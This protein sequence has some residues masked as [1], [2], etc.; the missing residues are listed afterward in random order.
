MSRQSI[1][2]SGVL[3]SATSSA[4]AALLTT[5]LLLMSCETG[6]TVIGASKHLELAFNFST[7]DVDLSDAQ[8][9]A[10]GFILSQ[11]ESDLRPEWIDAQIGRITPFQ[12][13]D[14]VIMSYEVEILSSIGEPRGW[15]MVEAWHWLDPVSAY[16]TSGPPMSIALLNDC[17]STTGETLASIERSGYRFLW[18]GHGTQALEVLGVDGWERYAPTPEI[19]ALPFNGR[20]YLQSSAMNA[21][22]VLADENL[23]LRQQFSMLRSAYVDQDFSSSLFQ[24]VA[25]GSIQAFTT[26]ATYRPTMTGLGTVTGGLSKAVGSGAASFSN[27][28]QEWRTW[29]STSSIKTCNTGCTPVAFGILFEYWDRNGYPNIVGSSS[30]NSNWNYQDSDVRWMLNELRWNMKTYCTSSGAGSTTAAYYVN[31]VDHINSRPS[32][33]GWTA[34]TIYVVGAWSGLKEQI[35]KGNPV[36]VHYDVYRKNGSINHSAAAYEYTDNTGSAN[37]WICAEKGW[38]TSGTTWDCFPPSTAG[39]YKITKVMPPK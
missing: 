1:A 30:D 8:A 29:N 7:P 6:E 3:Q 31:A 18:S 35:D 16:T 23:T 27:Y 2:R 12:S 19:A 38:N 10:E 9:I 28:V 13:V 22:L 20:D 21:D 25:H 39:Q 4:I 37:D 34:N 26:S 17:M 32:T 14:D 24:R 11:V 33:S 36:V 5:P 15:V